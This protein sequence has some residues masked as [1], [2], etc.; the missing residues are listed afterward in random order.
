MKYILNRL[1]YIVLKCQLSLYEN[2]VYA[3]RNYI[4]VLSDNYN[5]IEKRSTA[6]NSF[7]YGNKV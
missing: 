7:N 6:I 4:A 3:P 1:I 2:T 5:N